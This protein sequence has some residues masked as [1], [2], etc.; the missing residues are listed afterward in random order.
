MAVKEDR[1][2]LMKEFMNSRIESALLEHS[3]KHEVQGRK[4]KVTFH[5]LPQEKF[6]SVIKEIENSLN[7]YLEQDFWDKKQIL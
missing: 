7:E 6:K 1:I 4:S 5:Q 2:K 3:N